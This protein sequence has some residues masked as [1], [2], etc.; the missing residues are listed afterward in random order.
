[1]TKRPLR[2]TPPAPV[3]AGTMFTDEAEARRRAPKPGGG[4]V[5][6]IEEPTPGCFAPRLVDKPKRS[7]KAKPKAAAKAKRGQ[8]SERP[9]KGAAT[10]AG[11]INAPKGGVA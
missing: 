6:E 7:A 10:A 11:A 1:M 9:A 5:L 4:Q 3:P 2:T 8:P